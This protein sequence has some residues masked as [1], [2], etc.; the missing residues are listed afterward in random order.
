MVRLRRGKIRTLHYEFSSQLQQTSW[1]RQCTEIKKEI[2]SPLGFATLD[3]AAVLAL[4]T[5]RAV[6]DLRQTHTIPAI[7]QLPLL[8]GQLKK[9]SGRSIAFFSFSQN[10]N[11]GVLFVS[12]AVLFST[13]ILFTPHTKPRC[14]HFVRKKKKHRYGVGG[15]SSDWKTM[16]LSLI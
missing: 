15:G 13:E 6:T 11:T 1:R 2:H 10:D 4:A 3:K 14:C 5:S 9:Q 7:D 8:F 16:A 12:A